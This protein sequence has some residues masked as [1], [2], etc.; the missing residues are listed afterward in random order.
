MSAP[1]F[2]TQ[3]FASW[4]RRHSALWAAVWLAAMVGCA[5]PP[6]AAPPSTTVILLPD[7]DGKV[8]AVSVTSAE[9]S[10]D[11]VQ[12]YGALTAAAAGPAASQDMQREAVEARFGDL[13]KAQPSKPQRFVLYFMLDRAEL[14][15]ASRALLPEVLRAARERSPTQIAVYGHADALGTPQRNLQLSAQRAA[16]V[17]SMLRAADPQ[18]QEIEVEYFGD[19]WPLVPSQADAAQPLNRR[20]EVTIL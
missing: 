18:L 7:E 8:G 20:V 13:M 10:R 3:G 9:G 6:P 15:E 16:F 14:T 5:S 4:R 11:I 1:L 17:A 19:R 12:A 2:A